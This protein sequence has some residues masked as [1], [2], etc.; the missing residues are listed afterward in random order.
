MKEKTQGK[1]ASEGV[2]KKREWHSSLMDDGCIL[3][4]QIGSDVAQQIKK[5]LQDEIK[6][7][8]IERKPPPSQKL[9]NR[10]TAA[11]KPYM[12]PIAIMV[13]QKYT[14]AA[15]ANRFEKGFSVKIGGET[16]LIQTKVPYHQMRLFIK[17][18]VKPYIR[19]KQL[20]ERKAK[21]GHDTEQSQANP[22][23]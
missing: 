18:H 23:S 3:N 10:Y 22:Q 12:F 4:S 21:V 8:T 2:A 11:L 13:N 14:I 15:I 19:Q 5:E 7:K 1:N 9:S 16:Q 6:N 20:E 17:Q